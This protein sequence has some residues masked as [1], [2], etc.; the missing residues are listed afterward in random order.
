MTHEAENDLPE[1]LS[2]PRELGRPLRWVGR[3]AAIAAIL[4]AAGGI[5]LR[6]H[7]ETEV[8]NWTTAE[9]VPAVSL[10][11]P[12]RGSPASQ[13]ILPG[14]IQAW[15]DAP[16]YAR[17]NGYLQN[18][19]VDY[20]A[21]VKA[22]QILAEIDAP[23]LDGSF[24]AAKARLNAVK[25]QVK[26]RDAELAFAQTTYDRWRASPKGVVSIQETTSKKGDFESATARV[27]A[28]IADVNA[29][30]GEVDR[31]AALESFKRVIAPFDGVVTERNTDIGALINAGSGVG[32]GSGP[33]MFRV[34]DVSRMRIFVQ[35]PQKLSSR[36]PRGDGCRFVSAAISRQDLQGHGR[37]YGRCH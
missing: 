2:E 22:G 23:D 15:Y 35:V 5:V 14:D 25:A 8:K 10:I 6:W 27:N 24:A 29:A 31:L 12:E 34:A 13:L 26:V 30:Q 37:H 17:V 4:A 11:F 16:I 36:N 20:G 3:A 7:H 21:R 19:F 33:V 9:A 28:A 18:W 32:G 1:I